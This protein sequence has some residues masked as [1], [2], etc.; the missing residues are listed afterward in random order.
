MENALERGRKHFAN[1][2]FLAVL[3]LSID[4]GWGSG[5][6]SFVWGELKSHLFPAGI[7]AEEVSMRHSD[8]LY[9]LDISTFHFYEPLPIQIFVSWKLITVNNHVNKHFYK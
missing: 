7:L 4:E 5:A 8:V 1:F 2:C 3:E 9:R 6:E